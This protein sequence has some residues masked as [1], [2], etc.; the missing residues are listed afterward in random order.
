[1]ALKASAQYKYVT[2][3]HISLAKASLMAMTKFNGIE[4]FNILSDGI[5]NIDGWCYSPPHKVK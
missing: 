5:L 3:S 2:F 4:K 1:M